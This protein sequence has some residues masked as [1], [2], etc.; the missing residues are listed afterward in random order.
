MPNNY[1][2]YKQRV[3]QINKQITENLKVDLVEMNLI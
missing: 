3:K 1:L 2:F